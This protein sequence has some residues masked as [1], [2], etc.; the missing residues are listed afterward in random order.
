MGGEG[1]QGAVTDPVL[2]VNLLN[3]LSI[4]LRKLQCCHQRKRPQNPWKVLFS[5]IL[6][7]RKLK[8]KKKKLQMLPLEGLSPGLHSGWSSS[9]DTVLPPST[10]GR[11][12]RPIPG[13]WSL[14][15]TQSSFLFLPPGPQY[16]SSINTPPP[17]KSC[18]KNWVSGKEK[19]KGDHL[20][21]S[22]HPPEIQ[23]WEGSAE[24]LGHWAQLLPLCDGQH[25]ALRSQELPWR[26]AYW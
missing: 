19:V 17:R 9:Q 22:C 18:W 23:T 15:P 20:Q 7:M 24:G 26:H 21:P 3:V 6:Q 10:T 12:G 13:T 11:S 14:S 4:S 25:R 5:L 2:T 8:L 1:Q 16:P